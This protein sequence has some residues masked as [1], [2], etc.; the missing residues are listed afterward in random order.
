MANDTGVRGLYPI[1][2]PDGPPKLL[3]YRCATE[4]AIY[5]GQLVYLNSNGMLSVVQADTS[6]NANVALGVAWDFL[7]LNRAGLVPGMTLLPNSV[8][9]TSYGP[10]LP[11]STDA[12][13][14]VTYDPMQLYI[15]EEDTATTNSKTSIAINSLGNTISWTYQA[16][17][18]NVMSGFA[19]VTLLR[20]SVAK[21]TSN[22]LQLVNIYDITNQDGTQNTGGNYGKWVVR[23]YRHQFGQGM[24]P[25]PA[26]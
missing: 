26:V 9:A 6:T 7:D 10:F 12:F 5:R 16:T 13:V 22:L 21:T 23:I 3:Y 11:A 15:V 20:D 24:F 25:V 14:G 2:A 8:G 17:T 19:N 18:G 1:T 4:T